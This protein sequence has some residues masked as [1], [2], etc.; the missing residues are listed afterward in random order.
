MT[1]VPPPDMAEERYQADFFIT[2]EVDN[3][4][5]GG[6]PCFPRHHPMNDWLDVKRW[7]IDRFSPCAVLHASPAAE[8][9]ASKLHFLSVSHML[10]P[11]FRLSNDI[12]IRSA[13]DTA[14]E[15]I[16]LRNFQ[17]RIV[18]L[19]H[20]RD[21]DS[22][23]RSEFLV[24]QVKSIADEELRRM[25]MD[26]HGIDALFE[27]TVDFHN[28]KELSRLELR[29]LLSASSL[30]WFDLFVRDYCN[31]VRFSH[32]D[33]LDYPVA[34]IVVVTLAD[35]F[36]TH[37]SATS[38]TAAS[39]S[40]DPS[41]TGVATSLPAQATSNIQIAIVDRLLGEACDGALAR[42]PSI[43]PRIDIILLCV[44]DVPLR[45]PQNVHHGLRGQQ[46]AGPVAAQ[47]QA[48]EFN[49][50][51]LLAATLP[52]L[53]SKYE[54]R[55]GGGV[56]NPGFDGTVFVEGLTLRGGGPAATP[57]AHPSGRDGG[58]GAMTAAAPSVGGSAPSPEAWS[59][60]TLDEP[61]PSS[62]YANFS[63]AGHSAHAQATRQGTSAPPPPAVA[64]N[65]FFWGSQLPLPVSVSYASGTPS[66]SPPVGAPPVRR[67]SLSSGSS[68]AAPLSA[69]GNPTSS[70]S[71]AGALGLPQR[72]R[73]KEWHP[74]SRSGLVAQHAMAGSTSTAWASVTSLCE[75]DHAELVITVQKV[76]GS[77]IV[78]RLERRLRDAMQFI[79][80]HR[81]SGFGKVAAWFR[82]GDD[83]AAHGTA[84][85]AG[86][87][88]R[89]PFVRRDND[90]IYNFDS[91]EMTMRRAGDLAFFLRDY[92]TAT[93]FYKLLRDDLSSKAHTG[94]MIA[95]LNEALGLCL[96]HRGKLP[97]PWQL[98]PSIAS[99]SSS[100]A[101][102]AT[103]LTSAGI[104]AGT[105]TYMSTALLTVRSAASLAAA[106]SEVKL[107]D[108]SRLEFA[109]D[110]FITEGQLA[111]AFRVSMILVMICRNRSPSFHDRIL[112]VIARINAG[113]ASKGEASL[114]PLYRAVLHELA[115]CCNL[116]VNP[117]HP[118][119]RGLGRIP[120]AEYPYYC[121]PRRYA[122]NMVVAADYYIT[123][124][125]YDHALRCYCLAYAVLRH[126]RAG[127]RS[128]RQYTDR[129]VSSCAN[130]FAAK[131]LTERS[132][133]YFNMLL[134]Q[135]A[136]SIKETERAFAL[137]KQFVA[138][139]YN[140]FPVV[141]RRDDDETKTSNA[142]QPPVAASSVPPHQPSPPYSMPILSL[143][144]LGTSTFHP[145]LVHIDN[146]TCD[147]L[148]ESE[149][150]I[151]KDA[152][153]REFAAC[154]DAIRSHV[155]SS[156]DS[157]SPSGAPG[158][159]ATSPIS[160]TAPSASAGNGLQSSSSN[161]VISKWASFGAANGVVPCFFTRSRNALAASMVTSTP[162]T[163]VTVA[164]P[165]KKLSGGAS[166]SG[167]GGPVASA[168]ASDELLVPFA[169]LRFHCHAGDLLRISL[170]LENPLSDAIRVSHVSVM[171]FRLDACTTNG[172]PDRTLYFSERVA[173][174]RIER[175]CQRRITVPFR[176]LKRRLL[177]SADGVVAPLEAAPMDLDAVA[178]GRFLVVGYCAL[179]EGVSGK[180]WFHRPDE[181][182]DDPDAIGKILHD[183]A[184]H[185]QSC[186]RKLLA[187]S[188]Q[189]NG[190]VPTSDV[191]ATTISDRRESRA[192]K[193]KSP[194]QARFDCSSSS[195][196][197]DD[198][199]DASGV[200]NSG[201]ASPPT[202][203]KNRKPLRPRNR[204]VTETDDA[205]PSSHHHHPRDGP[206]TEWIEPC[207]I[208]SQLA[209]LIFLTNRGVAAAPQPSSA[210]P[211]SSSSSSST[212]TLRL[213]NLIY[214]HI[215]SNVPQL[216]VT[217]DPP[218]PA[219]MRDGQLHWTR[220]LLVNTSAQ[221]ACGNVRLAVA[222]CSG[223][224]MHI[225]EPPP[226]PSTTTTG[227]NDGRGNYMDSRA[228]LSDSAL[229]GRGLSL[230]SEWNKAEEVWPPRL[231]SR[232]GTVTAG[233]TVVVAPRPSQYPVAAVLCATHASSRRLDD[234]EPRTLVVTVRET[235]ELGQ[236]IV[237]CGGLV[238]P[239]LT[240]AVL[241][242]L[243]RAQGPGCDAVRRLLQQSGASA[244][245]GGE[246]ELV[247][248]SAFLSGAGVPG[249]GACNNVLAM[250]AAYSNVV[251]GVAPSGASSAFLRPPSPLA[252]A[253]TTRL[254][255]RLHKFVR[256]VVV[257]PALLGSAVNLAV[258][259]STHRGR[260]PL[261][262]PNSG[263]SPSLLQVSVTSACKQP[264]SIRRVTVAMAAAPTWNLKRLPNVSTV[265]GDMPLRR[266]ETATF[267]VVCYR[268]ANT[269]DTTND[270][271]PVPIQQ[272]VDDA[273]IFGTESGSSQRPVHPL[274]RNATAAAANG[275][276]SSVTDLEHGAGFRWF[277]LRAAV[278]GPGLVGDVPQPDGDDSFAFY[279]DKAGGGEKADDVGVGLSQAEGPNGNSEVSSPPLFVV[280]PDHAALPFLVTV[281]YS[282]PS[283]MR[284]ATSSSS[285][286]SVAEEDRRDWEMSA[287]PAPTDDAN[288][289]PPRNDSLSSNPPAD[290]ADDVGV[291][292]CYT[293]SYDAAEWQQRAIA[294]STSV[295]SAVSNPLPSQI[296]A[297]FLATWRKWLRAACRGERRVT[298][299]TSARMVSPM[300]RGLL[301]SLPS[302]VLTPP[303]PASTPAEAAMTAMLA[304]HMSV[305]AQYPADVTL[306]RRRGSDHNGRNSAVLGQLAQDVVVPLTILI[307]STLP[308]SCRVRIDIDP[309][310][311]L[312]N[313]APVGR[314]AAAAHPTALA[315][316]GL[317]AAT[318]DVRPY[319]VNAQVTFTL[320]CCLPGEHNMAPI[321]K[322]Y[323]ECA[324]P[325]DQRT[326]L[327]EPEAAAWHRRVLRGAIPIRGLEG[328]WRLRVR[329]PP[330][331]DPANPVQ[332]AAE[333]A[334]PFTVATIP[335]RNVRLLRP[336]AVE[337]A[338]QRQNG[339][340]LIVAAPVVGCDDGPRRPSDQNADAAGMDPAA[341]VGAAGASRTG[342][343]RPR[344]PQPALQ[345][346]DV[347]AAGDDDGWGA[348]A[349]TGPTTGDGQQDV[350]SPP[351][352]ASGA[353]APA[354]S[355]R[356]NDGDVD[357]TS[358]DDGFVP[359]PDVRTTECAAVIEQPLH[360]TTAGQ[361][362]AATAPIISSAA[363]RHHVDPTDGGDGVVDEEP[364]ADDDDDDEDREK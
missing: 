332:G 247:P 133:A 51:A 6:G 123:T 179:V 330:P 100:S 129:V 327:D 135:G 113:A 127:A 324:V 21:I 321:V 311:A 255:T 310:A 156:A 107:K 194:G 54:G 65:H 213:E 361:P 78:P 120:E 218:L 329:R 211:S 204:S 250:L 323:A 297:V 163:P 338:P 341:A 93:Y 161:L 210:T 345:G 254:V 9:L 238:I 149:L 202:T 276:A 271:T 237:D 76:V 144:C 37:F 159:A 233:G 212:S 160:I 64:R 347:A 282:L 106:A 56:A 166:S 232:N 359:V 55:R 358:T 220:M 176:P 186:R 18:P 89:E 192:P 71:A 191:T 200:A 142:A 85:G 48:K 7:T 102:V 199:E 33:T 240:C 215:Q 349:A 138:A 109:R 169:R 41:A 208:A 306:P 182:L 235:E 221:Q 125:N 302:Q 201:S 326:P 105:T 284:Q 75:L 94:R 45:L 269:A 309:G 47:T 122:A 162:V 231:G 257:Q 28:P 99:S 12:H 286:R 281:I 268:S 187:M 241:P 111:N 362:P 4:A 223:H 203:G 170:L 248:P 277:A 5:T 325:V 175:L 246:S 92:D 58:G 95:A 96:H 279:K 69:A 222:R 118:G 236:R 262:M 62:Y 23:V 290:A 343:E 68:A 61:P 60:A 229:P 244:T 316:H 25:A 196:S 219:A 101:V 35:L 15:P 356:D 333:F 270:T 131:G 206:R 307:T 178:G 300:V 16:A 230:L 355:N 287:L 97:L 296:A 184:M 280:P 136:A 344:P 86:G 126:R 294:A 183:C 43:D 205:A 88:K 304:G 40:A 336:T 239:P 164:T 173:V 259:N 80:D 305:R 114:H 207:F 155:S 10:R 193:E 124:E 174:G 34:L 134:R 147:A 167:T 22:H 298:P 46:F 273:M 348:S 116:V 335:R 73:T 303:E 38:Q 331:G 30:H 91:L 263:S 320:T 115:A 283:S 19:S 301:A 264:V 227:D 322:V 72:W 63:N 77:M 17:V 295:S 32:Y 188:P 313:N 82:S 363:A 242:I 29:S 141:A 225:L 153:E 128:L 261:G 74:P 181:G 110:G 299:S 364:S 224:L 350:G 274:L 139:H 57:H 198:A 209:D 293:T 289:E 172:A 253:A 267:P 190:S 340:C 319:Q 165:P 266:G 11:Y 312:Q 67:G 13:R 177:C 354:E 291:I 337:T 1:A 3:Q 130:L 278:Q 292:F 70:P 148:T 228:A 168:H 83:A 275:V 185:A 360:A 226:P 98:S 158:A 14:S 260:P 285:S 59:A 234:A 351:A 251:V 49:G 339:D 150:D 66:A 328:P 145:V 152:I 314:V 117:P 249:Y 265:P 342:V 353:H 31:M 334:T 317:S 140:N 36:P 90:Y 180:V 112:G 53:K 27:K 357:E 195:T 39:S 217:I 197:S 132:L 157:S 2:S 318:I 245:S 119:L 146:F 81:V 121:L 154:G 108:D 24:Q 346:G 20:A 214:V 103:V 171:Y 252:A 288:I 189:P 50:E 137:M 315:V 256:E 143:P 151:H 44:N 104:A 87:S 52:L 79:A 26:R 352:G 243:F 42:Q 8:F 258:T 216:C 308:F 272:F 84:G